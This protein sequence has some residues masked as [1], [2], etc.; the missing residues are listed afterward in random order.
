MTKKRGITTKAIKF[1]KKVGFIKFEEFSYKNHEGAVFLLKCEI[2]KWY[3]KEDGIYKP[4]RAG[5]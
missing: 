3:E 4:K 5:G 2:E 1:F